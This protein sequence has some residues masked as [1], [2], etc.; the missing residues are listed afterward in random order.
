MRPERETP[1]A[2][3]KALYCLF[4][5]QFLY[6][7]PVA[8]AV[9]VPLW[10]STS[11]LV[12]ERTM[13]MMIRLA[14]EHATA[15]SEGYLCLATPTKTIDGEKTLFSMDSA[16]DEE[17]GLA[18]PFAVNKRKTKDVVFCVLVVECRVCLCVFLLWLR[19]FKKVLSAG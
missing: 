16:N 10:K 7:G 15:I 12:V 5:H 6:F 1:T 8:V 14:Y 11:A 18:E 4:H 9:V 2:S 17:T 13:M 3:S 19:G